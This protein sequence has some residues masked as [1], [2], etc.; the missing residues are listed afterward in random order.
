MYK[1]GSPR[2]GS[3]LNN[4]GRYILSGHIKLLWKTALVTSVLKKGLPLDAWLIKSLPAMQETLAE[5][6]DLGDL[7]EKG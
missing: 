2:N 6:L 5:F 3:P 7:L 1:R 4:R